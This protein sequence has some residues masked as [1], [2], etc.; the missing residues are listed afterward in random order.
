MNLFETEKQLAASGYL[1]R[2]VDNGGA[3]FD[4]I[5]VIFSDGDCLGLSQSGAGFSQWGGNIDLQGIAER[6]ESGEEVDLSFGDLLPE[7]RLHILRRV[8]EAWRDSLEAIAADNRDIVASGREKAEVNDGT[9]QSGGKGI[10]AAGT[11]YCVRLDSYWGGEDRG[12]Y[13][14]PAEALAATLPDAYS[15]AGPEYHSS[16]DVD[17]MKRTKGTAA[18]LRALEKRNAMESAA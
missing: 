8:N 4:R 9:W 10:Y 15:L 2:I 6:V 5:T 16:V 12:P 3:T 17:S 14:S 11:A 13:T 18:R 7:L 1:F